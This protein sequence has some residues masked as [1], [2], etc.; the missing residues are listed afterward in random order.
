MRAFNSRTSTGV[1]SNS[2]IW[3]Y[4]KTPREV[5]SSTFIK[6]TNRQL[7]IRISSHHPPGATRGVAF[8]EAIRFLRTNTDKRQ[9]HKMLFLD[10][11]NLLRRGYPRKLINETMKSEI[12][13]ERWEDELNDKIGRKKNEQFT[14]IP[15]FVTK[16]GSRAGFQNHTEAL[17]IHKLWSDGGQ[18][19]IRWRLTLVKQS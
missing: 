13:H 10:K 2:L 5:T 14:E 15:T 12:L 18:R 7:Y 6:P 1:K 4:T 17:V 16:Y 3:P 8:G 19:Y 11:R 9:F